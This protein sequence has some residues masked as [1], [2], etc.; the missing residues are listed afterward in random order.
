MF[1]G[2]RSTIFENCERNADRSGVL[3][4]DADLEGEARPEHGN[5]AAALNDV[6]FDAEPRHGRVGTRMEEHPFE[7]EPR[8]ERDAD[9]RGNDGVVRNGEGP[10]DQHQDDNDQEPSA[11]G[12]EH[13]PSLDRLENGDGV[14]NVADHVGDVLAFDFGLW[15]QDQ[16]VSQYRERDG[17]H[18]L[19]REEM[20]ALEDGARG[21]SG[22][23]LARRAGWRRA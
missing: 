10:D 12:S 22:E 9:E 16:P 19:V 4:G 13:G 15:P 5:L 2:H 23:C 7:G 1:G 17:L 8:Q 11:A 14:K 3:D 18:V 6:P 20:P 21:R